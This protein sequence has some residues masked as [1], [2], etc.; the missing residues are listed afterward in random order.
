MNTSK[1]WL[2]CLDLTKM[3]EVL[4]GYTSFLTTITKPEKITFLHVIHSGPT[5]MEI[6]EQF[7][8]IESKEE[9]EKIL[10]D[11][12]NETVG[13]HFKDSSIEFEMILREGK[14]TTQI[15]DYVN[16]T[17]PDLL[18]VGKKVGYAGEGVMPKRILKYV[19]ASIL[20]V[21]ENCRYSLKKILVPVDF[22][23]QSA[24]AVKKA[25]ELAKVQVGEVIAQHIYEYRAQFFPY[26]LAED[27]KQEYDEEIE[28]KKD[29]FIKKYNIPEEV[30]FALTVHSS[31]K[32]AD[33]VY[34][35]TI[36]EQVDLITLATKIKKIPGL[37]RS[38]FTDKMVGYAFGI[39]ILV[40]KNEE[41]Y[42]KFLT[43]FFK[44]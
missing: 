7:P 23:E 6:I 13:N 35:Q 44:D 34:E 42:K 8:E 29:E 36:S 1:H 41:R 17:D 22:S 43:S 37:I 12:M 38:D 11:E 32:L 26:M 33:T 27:E 28:A 14:P 15:I 16:K 3:D 31:G 39:P 5:A 2:I 10:R 21:P 24:I 30:K 25:L 40:V 18:I 4:T 9:F 20:Y 19:S